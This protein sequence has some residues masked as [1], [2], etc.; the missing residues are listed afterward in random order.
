MS[1]IRK[2]NNHTLQTNHKTF[3]VPRHPKDNK[4]KTTS[5][6][7]LVKMIAKLA[8]TQSNAHQN[9]DQHRTLTKNGRYIKQKISNNRT[10]A[11]ERTA[12]SATGGLKC[13]YWRQISALDF[14]VVKTKKM[15]SSHGAFLTNAMHH[16]RETIYSN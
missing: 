3:I 4:S 10:S 11:L 9:K 8:R 14:V 6:L 7:F 16:H 15:F 13:I 2:Y 1:R 5:S 12:V